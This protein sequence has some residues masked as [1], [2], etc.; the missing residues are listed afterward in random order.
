MVA[1]WRYFAEPKGR[2]TASMPQLNR[3]RL[4]RQGIDRT[5]LVIHNKKAPNGA[6][7]LMKGF[8]VV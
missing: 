3:L 2:C 1:L 7:V 8:I 5:A 6:F 4:V